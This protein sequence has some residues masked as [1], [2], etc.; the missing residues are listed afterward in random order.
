MPTH[1]LVD[2]S[3]IK[4]LKSPVKELEQYAKMHFSNSINAFIYG[5][6]RQHLITQVR[7]SSDSNM[8]DESDPLI[9]GKKELWLVKDDFEAQKW[10]FT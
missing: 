2:E 3:L 5:E 8:I 7:I 6:E 10:I 4:D 9:G 1:E